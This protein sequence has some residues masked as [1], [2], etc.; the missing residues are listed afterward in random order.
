MEH[1]WNDSD[2]GRPSL[3]TKINPNYIQMSSSYRT[4]N[5]PP[6][7]CKET[8]TQCC[9]AATKKMRAASLVRLFYLYNTTRH[10]ISETR[11]KNTSSPWF[12]TIHNTYGC[13]RGNPPPK[14]KIYKKIK[15]CATVKTGCDV[16]KQQCQS[17]MKTIPIYSLNQREIRL[18]KLL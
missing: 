7:Y 15:K 17:E 8:A 5:T 14:K 2:R 9:I 18:I 4:V 13:D 1:W 3:K 12:A 6:L 11:N 10:L 16:K